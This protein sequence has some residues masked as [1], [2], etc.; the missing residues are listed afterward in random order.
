MFE[1]IT[2]YPNPNNGSNF[3]VEI[4]TQEVAK[5]GSISIYSIKGDLIKVRNIPNPEPVNVVN[6]DD[7]QLK[8]GLYIIEAIFGNERST[9]KLVVK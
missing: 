5:Q 1:R 4:V 2:V 8:S 3:K 6:F 9:K 7:L